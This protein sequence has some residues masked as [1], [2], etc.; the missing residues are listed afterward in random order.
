MTAFRSQH[1]KGN[2]KS[3]RRALNSQP[4]RLPP[5]SVAVTCDVCSRISFSTIV[6]SQGRAATSLGNR[7]NAGR[8]QAQGVGQP[9]F[10][11]GQPRFGGTTWVREAG[12]QELPLGARHA[13]EFAPQFPSK[14]RPAGQP[15]RGPNKAGSQEGGGGEGTSE[16][17]QPPP[18]AP[19][20]T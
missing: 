8:A 16:L 18:G 10:G 1:Q 17:R 7:E 11:S 15:R 20:P 6:R 19:S 13:V 5:R 12:G 4:K 9:Q 14:H 3:P 2:R